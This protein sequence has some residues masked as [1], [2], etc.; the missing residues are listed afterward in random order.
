MAEAGREFSN[1][2]FVQM[3][4]SSKMLISE[5]Q[6]R[7][8]FVKGGSS[9]VNMENCVVISKVLL[10]GVVETIFVNDDTV[11]LCPLVQLIFQLDYTWE[12]YEVN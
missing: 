11:W 9:D 7:N 10:K 2:V 12:L 6:C 3:H 1:I 8:I 5:G 4:R